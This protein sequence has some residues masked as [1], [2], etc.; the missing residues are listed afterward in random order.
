MTCALGR[1]RPW[2]G[3][4]ARPGAQ[5]P[6]SVI[7]DPGSRVLDP[8]SWIQHPGSWIQD[9]GSRILYPGSWIQDPCAQK[10][11]KKTDSEANASTILITRIVGGT[12]RIHNPNKPSSCAS[13]AEGYWEL[14]CQVFLRRFTE[15][16]WELSRRVYMRRYTEG[17]WELSWRF[18]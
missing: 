13:M 6:G 12:S 15:G 1:A 4:R 11:C 2:T 3:P 10:K 8:G 16:Y 17:C 5:D 14:S 7:Q 9:H 18:L